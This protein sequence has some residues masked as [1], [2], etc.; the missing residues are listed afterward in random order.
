MENYKDIMTDANNI[1]EAYLRTI[2]SS[3]WKPETQKC[4]LKNLN[5]R[6]LVI[7]VVSYQIKREYIR[8]EVISK[9]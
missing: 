7:L 8:E 5:L 9:C 1:Y 6:I 4:M 3:K 2:K